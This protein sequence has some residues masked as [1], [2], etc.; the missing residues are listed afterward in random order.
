LDAKAD[1]QLD[2]VLSLVDKKGNSS[3][4]RLYVRV[5][6]DSISAGAGD[7]VEQ[8]QKFAKKLTRPLISN[9]FD[10]FTNASSTVSHQ[11][12]LIS[13]FETVLMQ[14][15]PLVKIGDEISKVCYPI[16]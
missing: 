4:A 5:T 3:T 16:F 9:A 14:L 10:A 15:K 12:K 8:A 7:A 6:Q 11:E 13:S 2:V 1:R